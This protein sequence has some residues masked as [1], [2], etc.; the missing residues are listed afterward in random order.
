MPGEEIALAVV[1]QAVEK[2]LTKLSPKT[3]AIVFNSIQ[4]VFGVAICIVAVN[5]LYKSFTDSSS[6]FAD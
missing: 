4:A 6:E 5:K 2:G 1:K 3:K